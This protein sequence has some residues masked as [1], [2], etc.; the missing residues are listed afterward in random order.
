[1]A[2]NSGSQINDVLFS[3]SF[4][5]KENGQQFLKRLSKHTK[6]IFEVSEHIIARIS[7]Y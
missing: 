5:S 7:G 1:M 6:N 3:A 4:S 2:L